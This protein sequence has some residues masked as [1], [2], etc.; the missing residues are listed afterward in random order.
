MRHG[1][2]I[3]LHNNNKK[4]DAWCVTRAIKTMQ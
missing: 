4:M 2:S 1:I 3:S